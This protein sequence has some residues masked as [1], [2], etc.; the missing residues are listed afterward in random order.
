MRAKEL[1]LL[2]LLILDD[3]WVGVSRLWGE[4]YARRV[5]HHLQRMTYEPRRPPPLVHR[6]D[7]EAADVAV[8]ARAA[9]RAHRDDS[10]GERSRLASAVGGLHTSRCTRHASDMH[11]DEVLHIRALARRWGGPLASLA[12]LPQNLTLSS[13][14]RDA[15]FVL[16]YLGPD[17]HFDWH[18]DNEHPSCLRLLV[19]VRVEGCAYIFAYRDARGSVVEIPTQHPGQA[20]LVRGTSTHHSVFLN[21]TPDCDPARTRR[22]VVALQLTTDPTHGPSR[23][24]CSELASATVWDVL[25]V[26]GP[27]LLAHWTWCAL[28]SMAPARPLLSATDLPTGVACFAV[29]AHRAWCADWRSSV[30]FAVFLLCHVPCPRVALSYAAYLFATDVHPMIVVGG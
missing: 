23:T 10:C 7:V 20:L 26:V 21:A 13:H 6:V 16:D 1:T 29:C 30:S 4:P 25:W 22:Q 9:A 27:Y 17:A 28:A 14:H 3:R 18:Y 24:F 5:L 19:P 11:P 15:V 8:L 12:G 2:A